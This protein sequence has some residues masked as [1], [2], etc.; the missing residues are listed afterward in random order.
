MAVLL[1]KKGLVFFLTTKKIID[2]RI[3][4]IIEI[5]PIHNC[6]VFNLTSS[7]KFIISDIFLGFFLIRFEYFLYNLDP[8]IFDDLIIDLNME[9][10]D[11]NQNY[12]A[13]SGIGNPDS[14]LKTLKKAAPV[15]PKP[16]ANIINAKAK[17]KKMSVT[18]F[19]NI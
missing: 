13:F 16:S 7:D 1:E 9:E 11:I 8:K 2:I 15:N 5:Y 4:L 3:F 17:G 18:A 19:I 10:I 6:L 12:L 14:F